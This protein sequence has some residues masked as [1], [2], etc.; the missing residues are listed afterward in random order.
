G[1][2]VRGRI[3]RA[4]DGRPYGRQ[5]D[6]AGRPPSGRPG[7]DGRQAAREVRHRRR[8]DDR[9]GQERGG[10]LT[11]EVTAGAGLR[12]LAFARDKAAGFANP[13]ALFYDWRVR[14][15]TET[16]LRQFDGSGGRPVYIA[17]KEKGY[18]L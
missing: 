10:E 15:F 18:D 2:Q 3:H 1:R 9:G 6:A 17:D 16:E 4:Q 13:A 14:E 11:A 8:G 7:G 5:G 12:C